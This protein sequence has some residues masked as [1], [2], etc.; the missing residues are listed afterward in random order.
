M[1]KMD[2]QTENIADNNFAVL[3]KI[4]PNAVTETV[5]ENGEVIRCY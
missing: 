5:D 1:E 2:M 3:S 4:F